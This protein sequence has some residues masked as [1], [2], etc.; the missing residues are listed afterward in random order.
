MTVK[1]AKIN[2]KMGKKKVSLSVEEAK[3]LR[4]LLNDTFGEQKAIFMPSSPIII[5]RPYHPW[6]Y[7]GVDY[8]TPSVTW[9]SGNTTGSAATGA[10]VT[11]ALN[12]NSG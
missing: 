2:I 8:T 3:E 4:D 11:Y 9:T 5:D 10:T 6:R 12:S 7:W 1:I